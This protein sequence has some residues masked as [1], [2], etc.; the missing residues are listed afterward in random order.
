VVIS[1][2]VSNS[3]NYDTVGIGSENPDLVFPAIYGLSGFG[4]TITFTDSLYEITNVS[5]VSKPAYVNTNILLPN[6]VRITKNSLAIFDT[7]TY[8]FATFDTSF[9]KTIEN[10]NASDAN[11]ANV[12]SSV[13]AWNT[14]QI[15]TVTGTYTFNITYINTTTLPGVNETISKSYTQDYVWSAAS[16]TQVLLNLVSR[17]K[18]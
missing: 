8:D 12:N 2:S 7:E 11:T 17:S 14:P 16:G 3:V 1:Y 6:S 5:V 4:Y 13:F 9:N 10:Y 18:Y 15:R